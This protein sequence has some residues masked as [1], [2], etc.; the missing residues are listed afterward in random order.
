LAP[1]LKVEDDALTI[2]MSV[3]LFKFCLS[4]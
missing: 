3:L 1:F 2:Y 4:S